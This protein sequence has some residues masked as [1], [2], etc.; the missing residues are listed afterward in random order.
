MFRNPI[1]ITGVVRHCYLWA[2][3]AAYDTF[4]ANPNFNPETAEKTS[5]FCV[6]GTADRG[7][8]FS[9]IA[10]RLKN[11][12]PENIDGFHLLTF[13]GRMSG[14]SV[15]DFSNQLADKI[16]AHHSDRVVLMGH[17]RGALVCS[18]YA[19][20]LA[21]DH[22][23]QVDLVASL[24]GP[25]RGSHLAMWPLTAASSS[26]DEMRVDGR[27]LHDL[28]D[29]IHQSNIRYLFVGAE[30]DQLVTKDSHLPYTCERHGLNAIFLDRHGHLSVMSSHRLVDILADLIDQAVP[31]H[32]PRLV[33]L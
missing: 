25:F 32:Q 15:K 5:I 24:C 29:K 19:E 18:Y 8:S 31:H 20:Y 1:H 23:V 11:K 6:H 30:N 27:L 4:V 10:E 13:D 3:S 16:A 33:A 21:A 28:S 22:N 14:K 9:L 17:S 26:V 12:L 7:A 2:T